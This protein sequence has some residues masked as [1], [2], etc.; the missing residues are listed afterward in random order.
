MFAV[1]DK[2]QMNFSIRDVAPPTDV[3]ASLAALHAR[4]AAVSSSLEALL[5]SQTDLSHDLG[6]PDIFRNS[7]LSQAIA[8]RGLDNALGSSANTAVRLS[9]A[10]NNLEL[11]KQHIQQMLHLVEQVIE[12]RACI[13][14]VV[15]SM[16]APQD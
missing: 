12:L 7:L 15:G 3:R 4:E 8:F 16:G 1:L 10:V 6:R 5:A 13:H 11:E 2:S 14:G 9:N